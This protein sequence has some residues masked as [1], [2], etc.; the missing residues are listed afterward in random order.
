MKIVELET[1]RLLLRQWIEQDLPNFATLN[2]DPEV[3]EYFPALLS[4]E[5]SNAI[6]EKCKSLIAEKG[7]GVWAVELKSSG[8]FIGF[9]GLHT[10]K[11]NLAFSPCVEIS[12]RLHKKFWGSG[13]ATEAAQE[14]LSYAFNALNLN[15]VVSFTATTNSRSRSVMERLGFSNTHENFEHPDIQKGHSLSKHILYKI[16]KKQWQESGL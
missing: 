15:E 8:E 10:P 5:E 9:V 11:P 2:S 12:W 14:A 7:W 1:A 13:Y 6:T 16:T 3:M 4:R